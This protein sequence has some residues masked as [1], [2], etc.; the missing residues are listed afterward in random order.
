MKEEIN[1]GLEN[2][3]Q[4]EPPDQVWETIDKKLD[5]EKR[6]RIIPDW[7]YSGIGAAASVLLLIGLLFSIASP[8][9]DRLVMDEVIE[10]QPAVQPPAAGSQPSFI[11]PGAAQSLNLALSPQTYTETLPPIVGQEY[12]SLSSVNFAT[13]FKSNLKTY[14]WSFGDGNATANY[15]SVS[16]NSNANTLNW[17][18]GYSN[19]IA[20][21]G[22]VSGSYT[23][24]LNSS[25]HAGMLTPRES[26]DKLGKKDEER[27][28]MIG[29][30]NNRGFLDEGP[31]EESYAPLIENEYLSPFK[32]PL[33]TFS[34]DVDNASYANT[35]RM[36][37]AGQMPPKD[38]VRIE[39]F[40]NYF[41]YDYPQPE[42]G[43]PFSISLETASSPW[44]KDTRVVMIGLQG[45]DVD[46]KNLPP[47]NLVF[48]I[49]VSGSMED[50]NKLPLVKQ[51]L[52]LLVDEMRSQDR[53]AIVTYAGASGLALKSTACSEKETIKKAIDHLEAGGSTAGGEGIVLAYNVAQENL[54]KKGNNRIILLTDG[55]FN[56]GLHSD[57]EM[58]SLIEKKR[59]LGIYL[60]VCGFGMGNY[61]DS[62]LEILAD[63]GNGNY[64]YIDNFKESNKV[65][66]TGL[67]GTLLT[68][69]KDVKIQVEF[70]PKFVKAYRLIGY[71]N[72]KMP[73]QDF[74]DDTKDAGELGAGHTV[75]ALYEII[76]SGSK[77]S[78]PGFTELKYQNPGKQMQDYGNELLSVK[79][80]YKKP[81]EDVS[82]LLEVT[83]DNNSRSYK[84][85][86]DNFRYS[87]GVT[88][89]GM[90]LRNSKFK[91]DAN[92]TL[93][94]QLIE[95][96]RLNIGT[97]YRAELLQLIEKAAMLDKL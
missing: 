45:Y 96:S 47:S 66:S 22:T 60:T 37:Q 34:I 83:L 92:Y 29:E 17:T 54:N 75:T 53:I 72:R 26:K 25:N 35:R 56:V 38:A 91:G 13:V 9:H 6:R 27:W 3:P 28:I 15:G 67:T 19:G 74:E 76:T 62:K 87:C 59:S 5:E 68:I 33:S 70:N 63:Q 46:R 2:L 82:K 20:G 90:L 79:L 8:D 23:V 95:G 4:M 30:S 69:A 86:S 88:A 97:G 42:A 49:D 11:S 78:V 89:F 44:N 57:Q 84:D 24:T 14:S 64:Y 48:L 85:A 77:L 61:K 58:K 93:A 73:P 65:F 94:K 36:L 52:K 80:R 10:T 43:K 55:D 31:G 51:S 40:V 32:D 12:D 18:H 16:G 1:K 50:E 71:E 7:L 81:S 21:Y 41:D 39:E